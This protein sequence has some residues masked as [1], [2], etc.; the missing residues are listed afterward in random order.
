MADLS[1]AARNE[2]RQ[3][4]Q[5]DTF[6]R[7][8]PT[9]STQGAEFDVSN[10]L[11]VDPTG[12]VLTDPADVLTDCDF[13]LLSPI[14]ITSLLTSQERCASIATCP[15]SSQAVARR[16]AD[17]APEPGAERGDPPRRFESFVET[18][19]GRAR[20]VLAGPADT[21]PPVQGRVYDVAGRLVQEV[22]GT[23]VS[24]G[25]YV[26][27]WNGSTGAGHQAADGVYFLRV[28]APGHH[29]THKI[30]RIRR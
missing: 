8:R 3:D 27:E 4:G 13:N 6:V 12:A 15:G 26:L 19:A 23:L 2:V 18:V 25:R 17:R 21:E 20:V 5:D 11:W 28:E 14:V 30:V 1:T 9:S 16:G 7:F 10:Q 22:H 29:R 24:P